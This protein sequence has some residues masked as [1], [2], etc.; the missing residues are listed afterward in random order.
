M[1]PRRLSIAPAVAVLLVG[2]C[3]SARPTTPSRPGT[4]TVVRVVDGDTVRVKLGDT[5]EAVRLIG[6]DTPETHGRGGLRE[7]FGQEA[8]RRT[9]A[10]LPKG[11]RV[12]VVRDVEARDRY[13]RL[14]AYVY[15]EDDGMFV[16]LVLAREGYAAPLTIP[17]N[18]A[19]AEEIVAAAAGA[20]EQS[21]GL[22][23]R[24]GDADR[25]IGSQR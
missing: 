6:I 19:H 12:R 10:L 23:G 18:V 5:E 11:T 13:R 14:L 20:R 4:A 15:R 9:E 21:L 24:C 8:T 1:L 17:P 22:W 2:A 25:P 16:N 3:G 7:C